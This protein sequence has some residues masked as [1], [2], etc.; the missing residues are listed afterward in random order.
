MKDFRN[1]SLFS[2]LVDPW[3]NSYQLNKGVGDATMPDV[4]SR[5]PRRHKIIKCHKIS[6]NK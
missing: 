5:P 1:V 6:K 3:S 2:F 4:N